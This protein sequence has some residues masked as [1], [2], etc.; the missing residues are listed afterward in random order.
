TRTGFSKLIRKIEQLNPSSSRFLVVIPPLRLILLG[1]RKEGRLIL[2]PIEEH[3]YFKLKAGEERNAA[4]LFSTLVADPKRADE[5][6]Q[7]VRRKI[8]EM[9]IPEKPS[10]EKAPPAQ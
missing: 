10:T 6:D 2:I 4:E 9:A 3:P 8:P 5:T 7:H 1:D